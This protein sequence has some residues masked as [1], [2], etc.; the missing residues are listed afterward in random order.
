MAPVRRG[1]RRAA[2]VRQDLE[3]FGQLQSGQVRAEAIV[4]AAAECQHRRRILAGDVEAVWILV[5]ARD[6]GWLQKNSRRCRCHWGMCIRPA[7]RLRVTVR[8]VLHT[9]GE[10]RMLSS[11]AGTASS[12][13]SPS[14]AHCS[15]VIEQHLH[16][17]GQLIAGG[18]RSRKQQA[19]H[20]SYVV[21]RQS[22]RSPSSSAR[23]RSESRSSVR[24]CRRSATIVVDIGVELGPAAQDRRA[25]R[26]RD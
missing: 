7:R 22:S 25:F 3:S 6:R 21:R 24:R 19:G 14:I 12:G 9:A 2:C 8:T 15:R 26:R 4:H 23:I 13:C 17:R 5:D 11:T 16:G 10:W 20:A 18:I 1:G